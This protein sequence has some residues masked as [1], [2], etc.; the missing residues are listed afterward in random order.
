MRWSSWDFI[1]SNFI[2][3]FSCCF[4]NCSFWYTFACICS[5]LFAMTEKFFAVITTQF[6]TYIFTNFFHRHFRQGTTIHRPLQ[7]SISRLNWIARHLLYFTLE[8]K[9]KGIFMLSSISK[10][11]KFWSINRKSVY[12]NS[13]LKV[14]RNIKF[15]REISS[16]WQKIC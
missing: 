12:E 3:S 14:F 9:T 10:G 11:L 8:L 7:S 13:E 15:L 6:F 1:T 5:E 2:A 16:N 4:F